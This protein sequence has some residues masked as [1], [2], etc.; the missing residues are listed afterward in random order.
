MNSGVQS[1][2]LKLH[3]KELFN[4]STNATI[5]RTL[6]S[7][8]PRWQQLTIDILREII[9]LQLDRTLGGTRKIININVPSKSR[10]RND[11][12]VGRYTNVFPYVKNE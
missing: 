5:R 11:H 7:L 6:L 8:L 1:I 3:R 10:G 9:F 2:I 4:N 12:V